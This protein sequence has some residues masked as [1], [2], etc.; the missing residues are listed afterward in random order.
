MDS[1]LAGFLFGES[2][3]ERAGKVFDIPP[4]LTSSQGAS[5][6]D[7][8]EFL[9]GN[10]YQICQVFGAQVQRLTFFALLK[11][12]FVVV[13]LGQM[14]VSVPQGVCRFVRSILDLLER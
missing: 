4:Y 1:D 12:G 11:A 5:W 7:E 8:G 13:S 6:I 3:S 14:I 2:T 10:S 9:L